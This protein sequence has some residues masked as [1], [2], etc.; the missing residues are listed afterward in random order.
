[1]VYGF[2]IHSIDYNFGQQQQQQQ[3]QQPP[4]VY[5]S[6]FY[7]SEGNDKDFIKRQNAIIEKVLKDYSFKFQCEHT[8][9]DEKLYPD[10]AFSYSQRNNANFIDI[11]GENSS[12][13]GI[14]R[15]IPINKLKHQKQQ[16]SQQ[17]SQQQQFLQQ[18]N[19]SNQFNQS[20]NDDTSTSLSDPS[21]YVSTP[22]FVIWKKLLGV[23]FTIIC[24]E[25]ENRLLVSNFLTMFSNVILDNFKTT[26]SKT[27]PQEILPKSDE[28]LLLLNSYLPNG[29]LLFISNQFSKQI[30][31]N[32]QTLQQS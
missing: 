17:Q 15:I 16:Q 9:P 4:F 19:F 21:L 31:T 29:Q 14:F 12:K 11:R 20:S 10:W 6:Q 3:Q 32:I 13:E 2:I 27:L 23:C 24:E 1:M 26:I 28:I 8:K 30:K 7:T 5:L 25:D 18:F 22:K